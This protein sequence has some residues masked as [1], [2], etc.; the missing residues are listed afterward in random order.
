MAVQFYVQS[1]VFIVSVVRWNRAVNQWMLFVWINDNHCNKC[2]LFA[3]KR[4]DTL[5]HHSPFSFRG[6]KFG[7]IRYIAMCSKMW[8][9]VLH[10]G[11]QVY[12][13][14]R[15][16]F[17]FFL[18]FH[19]CLIRTIVFDF[20]DWCN[21]SGLGIRNFLMGNMGCFLWEKPAVTVTP[22]S[23]LITLWCGW[24]F[25]RPL[26]LACMLSRT[27]ALSSVFPHNCC[28]RG[29]GFCCCT[30]CQKWS[31]VSTPNPPPLHF[32]FLE[33]VNVKVGWARAW[34]KVKR[35]PENL[36]YRSVILT[37]VV[38]GCWDMAWQVAK[39][40]GF[41]LVR[42]WVQISVQAVSNFIPH[43]TSP[44]LGWCAQ[45]IVLKVTA[46]PPTSFPPSPQMG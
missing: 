35:M 9:P 40:A 18:F 15:L 32:K 37:S 4:L 43:P 24:S 31:S 8:K 7:L 3:V 46:T 5:H 27:H 17:S 33:Q 29:L 22:P 21:L 30:P 39:D 2:N 42:V 38:C 44:S 20:F 6:A 12:G 23:L 14:S 10:E 11:D 19:C 13:G 25:L 28:T 36:G 16:L 45:C 34:S 41:W 26:S 1:R